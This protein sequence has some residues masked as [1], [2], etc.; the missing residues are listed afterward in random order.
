MGTPLEF[1]VDAGEDRTLILGDSL[2]LEATSANPAPGFVEYIWTEPYTGTL[3]CT[4]CTN[5]WASPM[6]S[7][8]Y[9]LLG[10]DSKGCESTDLIRV[11]VEKP[12]VAMV[13]T[14][15]TPNN[16][17]T[18]DELRAQG[19]GLADVRVRIY[20]ANNNELVFAANSLKPWDGRDLNGEPCPDGYY[21][22]AIEAVTAE[23]TPITKGQAIR[24]FR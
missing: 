11:N 10:I 12:R 1:V 4:E 3:S 18:N 24:L 5:P 13:P 6:Y 21:F 15:F 22:Y 14:G 2:Q 20:N 8:I 7:I 9:E 19:T 23:G 16:D 17:L